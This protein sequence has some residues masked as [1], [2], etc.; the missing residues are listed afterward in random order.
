MRRHPQEMWGQSVQINVDSHSKCS[1]DGGT[2]IHIEVLAFNRHPKEF[3][4]AILASELAQSMKAKGIDVEPQWA[5]GAKVLFDG[6]TAEATPEWPGIEKTS[7]LI[8]IRWKN[9][10]LPSSE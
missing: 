4:E 2:G 6:V 7:L 8:K 10:G 3:Q 9:S 1:S 5:N